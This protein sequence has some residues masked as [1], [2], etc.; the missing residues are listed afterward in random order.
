MG[1][2]IK[3][4][5]TYDIGYEGFAVTGEHFI[6][7]DYQGRKNIL[8]RFDCGM[9]KNTTSTLIKQG[10]IKYIKKGKAPLYNVG[11]KVTSKEGIVGEIVNVDKRKDKIEIIFTNGVTK[12]F[13]ASTLKG[14]FSSNPQA[15]VKNGD[16][17]ETSNYGKVTVTDYRNAREVEVV[18]EDGTKTITQATSLRLGNVGHP[19]SGTPEGFQFTNNDGVKGK[20]LTYH[21][22]LNVDVLWE[23]GTVT[24][25][26]AAA[27]IKLGGVYC[28][29][30]KSVCGVG[31]FGV[32]LFKPNRAGKKGNYQ[33]RIYDSWMRMIRRCYDEKEQKKPSCRAYI[34]VTV[35]EDWHNFQ[36]FCQWALDNYPDKFVEGYELDK[37]L[38]GDGW[39]YSPCKCTLLPSKVNWFLCNT[40][41]NKTS[42]LPEGV[43][44]IEPKTLNSKTGYV[45]R[46]SINGKREY[47]GF[48]NTPE[49]AGAVY[50]EAKEGEA[51]RLA[52]EYKDLLTKNQYDKL[53]RFKLEDIHRKH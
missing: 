5:P 37:D 53:M 49:Q 10:K 8:I 22:P 3:L 40:Y 50:R 7:V 23:D 21:D 39:E 30:F 43:N 31:Y 15:S 29:S 34:G 45:A 46:C 1:K 28:P 33:Q 42:G 2:Q 25:N 11:C 14:G 17:Y 9:E 16:V 36:N 38:F 51:R 6:V 48:Y 52:E 41:S 44:V 24:Y 13:S 4:K 20:V 35:C 47:L 27:N 26:H 12:I 19:K 18:F 32:G